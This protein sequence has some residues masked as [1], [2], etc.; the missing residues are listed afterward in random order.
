MNRLQR[1]I[2]EYNSLPRRKI[3]E[4]VSLYHSAMQ[5]KKGKR[6]KGHSRNGWGIE[7]TAWTFS[8]AKGKVSELITLHREVVNATIEG[9]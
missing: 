9:K 4:E 3:A 2:A 7:D 8:M 5:E 1:L 6:I